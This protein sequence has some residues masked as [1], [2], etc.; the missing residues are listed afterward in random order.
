M[1]NDGG[2]VHPMQ[3]KDKGVYVMQPGLTIRDYFAAQFAAAFV[4]SR[5][6]PLN[7]LGVLDDKESAETFRKSLAAASY[8]MADAMLAER[9]KES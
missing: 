5:V 3:V 8:Y 7:P 4:E 1:K 2:P 9:A 6:A